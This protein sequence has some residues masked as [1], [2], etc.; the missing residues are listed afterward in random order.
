MMLSDFDDTHLEG[1]SVSISSNYIAG[2]D[3]LS[4][5]S[6]ASITGSFNTT[7][8][9]LT[10]T[11]SDTVAN[12]QTALRSVTYRNT[13]ETPNTA[14]RTISWVVNDGS[15][16]AS[17]VNTTIKVVS[18]N[19]IPTSV[20]KVFTM[21]KNTAYAFAVADFKFTDIDGDAFDYVKITTLPTAG[22]LQFNGVAVT[23][24][25]RITL[26][27]LGL[28]TFTPTVGTHGMPYASFGFKVSDGKA[29]SVSAYTM[30]I[31][32]T[33]AIYVEN[34]P[35]IFVNPEIVIN[36]DS[37]TFSSARIT[38]SNYVAGEDSLAFSALGN[39]SGQFNDTTGILTLSGVDTR[40]V[41]QLA[42]R[43]VSYH[44]TSDNPNTDPRTIIWVINDGNTDFNI[45]AN[46]ITVTRINDA[47]TGISNIFTINEDTTLTFSTSDFGFADIDGGP[48]SE[49]IIKSLPA[50]GSLKLNGEAVAAN[51][52]I[53]VGSL[54]L[55]SFTPETNSSGAPYASFGFKLSDGEDESEATYT[56]TINVTS[57]NDAP[58][59]SAGSVSNYNENNAALVI[60]S[61]LTISDV[62]NTT[63]QGATVWI[64]T[65]YQ[66]GEDILAFS[67]IGSISGKFDE[68]TGILTLSGT[69]TSANYQAA[70][71]S[72]TYRNSSENPNMSPRTISWQVNDGKDNSNIATSTITVTRVND[73]PTAANNTLT[74]DEDTTLTFAAGDFGFADVDGGAR[75]D[76]IITTLPTGNLRFNGAQVVANQSIAVENLG[77]LTFT[78]TAN[79]NGLP[80]TSFRFKVSDGGLESAST[81]TMTINVNSV[82]DLPVISTAGSVLNYRENDAASVIDNTLTVSDVDT[83]TLQGASISISANYRSGEDIL[84]FGAIGAI[85]GKFDSTTGVLMLSGTD[86]LANYQAV[87]RSV[88]YR[89]TSENPNTSARTISWRVNDGNADSNIA[90]STINVTAVNDAPTAASNTRTISEDTMLTFTASDFGFSDVDGGARS[91]IIITTLPAAGSLKFNG[92]AVS[93]NQSIAVSSLGLLTFTPAANANGI[94]YASF[95]FKVSDGAAESVS[96]YTMTINV[97]AETEAPEVF[98]RATL[99]IA[100]ILSSLDSN[101]QPLLDLLTNPHNIDVENPSGTS[102][103]DGGSDMYD[104]GNILKTNRANDITY[105]NG[106]VVDG[107]TYFGSGSKYFTKEYAPGYFILAASKIDITS[108]S[109][110]G[111]L[112]ADGAGSRVGGDFTT[113][114]GEYRVFYTLTGDAFDASVN[115]I[116]IV[117]NKSGVSHTFS[118]NTNLDDHTI[119]LNGSD[120]LYYILAAQTGGRKLTTEQVSSIANTFMTN[121]VITK[122]AVYAAEYVENAAAIIANPNIMAKDVDS[123]MLNRATV[124]VIGSYFNKEDVL[125]FTNT[126]NITGSFNETTGVLTLTGSDTLA[127]YQTALRSVSY[128]NTSDNPNTSARTIHWTVNDGENES[129]IATSTITITWVNDAPTAVNNTLTMIGNTTLNFSVN[130]FG[131]AD[132]DGGPLARIVITSLP[133]AGSLRVN[134]TTVILNQ[135]IEVG[136]PGVLSFTPAASHG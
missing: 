54:G 116:V 113:A 83:S 61:A 123:A 110:T 102:I 107:A 77:L 127:N 91:D 132:V 57:V 9:V 7:T 81:Y 74:I 112:G 66:N 101:A 75:S 16:N 128:R 26:G 5:A 20:S 103:N 32:V 119:N 21:D 46:A 49:V 48:R 35:A 22:S 117:K 89:N 133:T 62:D 67:A 10:L 33:D 8:G 19:D 68:S 17:P 136:N 72:V 90:T 78:P 59:I 52:S 125:A 6:T 11:G 109:I 53:P 38:I 115:H 79:T 42:L 65:N 92:V 134:G 93:L 99:P 14:T 84:A 41:Y 28:L 15:L 135:V 50:A 96:T 118:T 94:P 47:P 82:N 85:S 76:I 36:V 12:Y 80:Y 3:I 29:E 63:L 126:G 131:F 108:F 71:R 73:A 106:V 55:L 1:A 4:F 100:E 64:S 111:G 13:S 2:Q 98:T 88:T 130:E 24:G 122:N 95:G 25:Q 56:M 120:E 45:A 37:T 129:N 30:T 31:N 18:I 70:L 34:A 39:I 23:L 105:T 121:N 69:D 87:L 43:A 44:N 97:T 58:I 27:N 40:E 114:D 51:Q 104:V 86:T 124:R 60:D